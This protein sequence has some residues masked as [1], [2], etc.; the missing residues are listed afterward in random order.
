[1]KRTDRVYAV[2]LDA[3]GSYMAVAGR[4]RKVAMYDT[5]RGRTDER[6]NPLEPV[7]SV[8]MWEHDAGDFVYCVALSSDMQ[9]VAY[10]GTAKK[11]VILSAMSGTSLFELPQSGVIWSVALLDSVRGWQL[12]IGGEPRGSNRRAC[13]AAAGQPVGLE[14][15]PSLAEPETSKGRRWP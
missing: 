3:S 11:A 9:Y 5:D 4:D 6:Q 1:M 14:R 13:Q 10:G 8:L 15:P 7:E 2:G 12:A